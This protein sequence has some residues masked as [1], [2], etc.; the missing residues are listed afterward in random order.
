MSSDAAHAVYALPGSEPAKLDAGPSFVCCSDSAPRHVARH[1]ETQSSIA[2]SLASRITES[3]DGEGEDPAPSKG[4]H[5]TS[6]P[7]YTP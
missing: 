4:H 6:P 5:H 7:S 2:E 3:S 1:S